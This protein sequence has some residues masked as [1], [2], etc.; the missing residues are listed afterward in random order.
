MYILT[1]H[2]AQERSAHLHLSHVRVE[3]DLRGAAGE[4]AFFPVTSTFTLR[5]DRE[6]T[7]VDLAGK[8]CGVAVNGNEHPYSHDGERVLLEGLPVGEEFELAVSAQCAY[9]RTGEGLHRYVDPE[10]QRVYLYTQ[11]EPNDAHRAWPC[12]DQPDLK[13]HWTFSV[14]APAGWVVTSNGALTDRV[15]EADSSVHVFTTTPPLSSYITAVVAGQWA[16]VDGGTWSGELCEAPIPLRLM[17]RQSLLPFMDSDDILEVTRAGLDFFHERYK[18]AYPWGTYDQIFVPEYN[19]GAMENPGCVTFTETYLSRDTPTFAQ[20]Q[21]RANT[22]LHEMCHMWFGDLATPAWWD[23][24]WLKESFAENQGTTAASQATQYTGEWASFAIGRKAWAYGQDQYPTTHPIAADIPDVA[25]AKNNFDGITYAKGAAVL[26]QLVAWVGEDAFYAGTRLYFQ[27][28]AFAATGLPDLLQAL[29]ESCGTDLTAWKDAWLSTTGPSVLSTTW[30]LTPR[31]EVR[32]LVLHQQ[33]E[34]RPHCLR[35]STWAV[36]GSRLERTHDFAVRIDGES[37]PIDPEG[38][39]DVP[40]GKN[41]MDLLLINDGDLTY[42]ISR[43]DKHSTETALLYAHTIADPTTRAVIWASLW[44]AVRDGLLDPQRF[45]RAALAALPAESED[46]I[47]DRLLTCVREAL[48]FLPSVQ[49]EPLRDHAFRVA[50]REASSA[51]PDRARSWLLL[52]CGLW[53]GSEISDEA[54]LRLLAEGR[55]ASSFP[56]GVA[57][58]ELA[59]AARTA[60]A[61]RAKVTLAELEAWRDADPTGENTTRFLR[62]RSALPDRSVREAAWESIFSSQLSNEHLSATLAG[63]TT[64]SWEEHELTSAFFESV[65]PFWESHSIGMGIRF[66]DGG[67]PLG[68]ACDIPERSEDL[69]TAARTWSEENAD[70]AGALHRLMT[71]KIDECERRLRVQKIWMSE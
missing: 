29:S 4:D 33:G 2:D 66:V 26:K 43:L 23:D 46:A 13:P 30:T 15:D 54:V 52:A 16:V 28:H 53:A 25:A 12:F 19:L 22:I 7:F 62:S 42:A 59:W 68:V 65:R 24:L 8:V 20:R 36:R 32:D 34:P 40:A 31:G 27:R 60:L 41:E 49:R 3:L 61:A 70:A 69:L 64:S 58:A 6:A 47:A 18:F 63:L 38:L 37:A 11:F 56:E 50:V 71:E 10:D 45:L 55:S 9:S 39:L 1:R 17:C 48:A 5:T 67:F 21:K 57:G 14:Q 51:S 44:N 35:V